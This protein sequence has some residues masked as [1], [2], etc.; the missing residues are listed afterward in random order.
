MDQILSSNIF[1]VIPY[2]ID[3]VYNKSGPCEIT[4][5]W[6]VGAPKFS[7][8]SVKARD[9]VMNIKQ[10]INSISFCRIAKA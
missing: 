6:Q 2:D 9:N 4:T 10:M 5:K 7:I 1:D 3:L 8:A